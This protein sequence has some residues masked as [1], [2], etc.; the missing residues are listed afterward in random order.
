MGVLPS[1]TTAA[2][3]NAT[4]RAAVDANMNLLRVWGGGLYHVSSSSN[5]MMRVHLQPRPAAISCSLFMTMCAPHKPTFSCQL[6]L[7]PPPYENIQPEAFYDFCDEHGILVWQDAMFGGSHYPRN[8]EF[9][10]NVAEEITQ[11]V[12]CLH[13]STCVWVWMEGVKR[14]SGWHSQPVRGQGGGDEMS[15]AA[16][17]HLP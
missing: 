4:L 6:P 12:R 16:C 15:R 9:L 13:D 2:L 7:P 3:I 14:G 8:Q 17:V 1:N 11:Q 10:A 5:L